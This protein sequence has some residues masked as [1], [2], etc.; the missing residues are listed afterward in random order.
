MRRATVVT[1]GTAAALALLLSGCSQQLGDRKGGSGRDPDRLSD[2]DY[3]EVYRNIDNFPNVAKVCA[4][5]VAFATTSSSDG[6]T[7]PSLVRVPEWDAS[8][9]AATSPAATP[10][11]SAS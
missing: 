5:G 4:G 9:P 3:V 6:T 1:A 11:P 2:V 8:C 7:S 10:S